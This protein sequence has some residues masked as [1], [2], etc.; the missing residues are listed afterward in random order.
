MRTWTLGWCAVLVLE[1]GVACGGSD[2]DATQAVTND[3]GVRATG[4][5]DAGAHDAGAHDAGGGARR[6]LVGAV[7]DTDIA[8]GAIIEDGRARMFFCGGPSSYAS[9]TH[10]FA[11]VALDADSDAGAG[12]EQT[13]TDGFVVRGSLAGTSLRGE[14]TRKG[15]PPATFSADFVHEDTLAGLYEGSDDCGRLG[16]IVTQTTTKKA[17]RAQGACVGAGHLPQQVNPILP[18]A[19]GDD[20]TIRVELDTG[21]GKQSARVHVAAGPVMP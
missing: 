13:G 1:M 12:F 5:H 3:S 8:L 9:A 6:V 14:Y 7:D 17:A 10:W 15:E 21:D 4:A 20:G 11:L 16:L 2:D 19:L 18:V